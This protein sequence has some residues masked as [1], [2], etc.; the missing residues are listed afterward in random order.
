MNSRKQA[1]ERIA[2]FLK[3]E[4]RFLK[5]TGT[6]QNRKH[7]LV[8]ELVLS[9]YLTPATILFRANHVN[10]IE[11]FV[12]PLLRLPKSP[13]PGAQ[14]N[15]RGGYMLYFDTINPA[16]WQSSPRQI[17]VAIVYPLDSLRAD[18]GDDC[19]QDL[20]H[21]NARKVFLVSWTDNRD[22]SWTKQFE[23]V[24]VVYDAEEE[25]PD[26]HRRMTEL[27]SSTE[28]EAIFPKKPD[29]ARS[30]PDIYLV[31]ILCRGRC[32]T[33]RWAKLNR[34][35]P[36]KSSLRAAKMGEYSATCLSCGYVATDNYNWFR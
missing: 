20:L 17:D 31:K 4:K 27:L 7:L 35:Y 19:V 11:S 28:P 14:F 18:E 26:Y 1:E 9:Q 30:T 2:I 34:P 8:I 23:P 16:S 12:S 33:T 25:D 22:F 32:N 13:K 21:R 5:L 10:N 3:S 6:H 15:V 29:Y 36:G 24:E